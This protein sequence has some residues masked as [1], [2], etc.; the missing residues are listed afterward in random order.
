MQVMPGSEVLIMQLTFLI[1]GLAPAGA[2]KISGQVVPRAVRAEC[3][4]TSYDVLA[5]VAL[6]VLRRGCNTLSV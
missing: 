3:S 2:A 1:T 5:G 4:L 6:G